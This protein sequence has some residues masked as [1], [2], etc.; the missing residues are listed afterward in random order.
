MNKID[1]NIYQ[2]LA[3]I[4]VEKHATAEST[5][6]QIAELYEKARKEISEYATSKNAQWL[7]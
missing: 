3:L 6:T 7:I 4:Y 1:K 5:P 2:E